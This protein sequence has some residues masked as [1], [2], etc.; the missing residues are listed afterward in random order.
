MADTMLIC[1]PFGGSGASFFRAWQPQAPDGLRIVPI[2]LPGREERFMEDPHID[3]SAAVAEAFDQVS[4]RVA[5]GTRTAL[6]GHSLGAVLA[7]ELARRLRALPGSDLAG[8]FVSGSPEPRR[9]RA[10]R[11]T[12][13]PDAEFIERLAQIAGY[14]HPVM[15]DE[16]IR[17]LMLPLLRADVQM[18]EDYQLSRDEPLDIPVTAIRGRDDLLVS[19]EDCALWSTVTS[20]PFSVAELD[21][22]HMYLLDSPASVLD[23]IESVL[24]QAGSPWR[25]PSPAIAPARR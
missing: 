19:A 13:L 10:V 18:H 12:G 1:M 11:A 2:Q 14:R 21:G 24:R 8:L 16:E 7:F 6:F 22:G 9:P 4:G 3:A 20:A 5:E 23:L 15:D 25:P 17:E